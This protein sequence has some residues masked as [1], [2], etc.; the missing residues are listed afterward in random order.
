MINSNGTIVITSRQNYDL[1][2]CPQQFSQFQT[3]LEKCKTLC[4]RKQPC[5]DYHYEVKKVFSFSERYS[6]DIYLRVR[7]KFDD[8]CPVPRY[9]ATPKWTRF[10]LFSL[11]EVGS[12]IS[13]WNGYAILGVVDSL[14]QKMTSFL[15]NFFLFFLIKATNFSDA[16][17]ALLQRLSFFH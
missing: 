8:S 14:S 17:Y 16:G 15:H 5:T 13:L 6:N 7:V 4:D 9:I 1:R 3:E 11:Y 10:D 2:L 12:L